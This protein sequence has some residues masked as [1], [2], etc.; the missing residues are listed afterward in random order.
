MTWKDFYDSHERYFKVG[1][2]VLPRIDPSIPV[3]EP[4]EDA[5]AQK[6]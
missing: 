6:A 3:P 1:R 2:V 4:C 5:S